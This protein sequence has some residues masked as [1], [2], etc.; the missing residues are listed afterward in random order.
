MIVHDDEALLGAT[1]TLSIQYKIL[2]DKA[3]GGE[4]KKMAADRFEE[5][6]LRVC[7]FRTRC[8]FERAVHEI[9]GPQAA[10][11][12]RLPNGSVERFLHNERQIEAFCLFK[13]GIKP[14]WEDPVNARGGHFRIDAGKF[15]LVQLAQ[16]WTTIQ[17][18]LIDKDKD[19]LITGA[20]AVDKT[21]RPWRRISYHL[22]IWMT[23][24]DKK[25]VSLLLPLLPVPSEAVWVAH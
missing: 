16:A 9:P 12:T 20:R 1:W 8:G 6:L 4:K 23:R 14:L 2:Q 25:R 7:D 13:S 24:Q 22:E 10:F 15:S 5:N 19:N 21:F 17:N 11:C 3:A 18:F